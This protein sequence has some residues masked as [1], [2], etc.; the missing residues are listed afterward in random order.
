M[1]NHFP[2][3]NP[4]PTPEVPAAAGSQMG[5]NRPPLD[6]DARISFNDAIDQREGFRARCDELIAAAERA[7]CTDEASLGRCG[8]LAKQIRA[9]GKVIEDTHETVKKPYLDAGRVVD[10]MKK[11]MLT[12]LS[13]A[14][15][16][17]ERKQNEYA[18]EQRQIAL[19]AQRRQ[20]EEED[21]RRREEERRQREAEAQGQPAPEPTLTPVAAPPPPPITT[22]VVARGDYG[23]AVSASTEF[24]ATVTDYELAF[25]KVAQNVKVREAID[26][27]ISALVRAGERDIPGVQITERAKITNR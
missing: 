17:V 10:E 27:A 19:A 25:I 16:T 13:N 22:G 14:K 8:E 2:D 20:R 4:F 12:P 6:E 7:F 3:V 5:H 1:N 11:A 26:K 24:I 21:A 23:A 18:E 15:A 9:A